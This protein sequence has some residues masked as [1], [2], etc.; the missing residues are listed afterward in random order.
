M[1]YMHDEILCMLIFP[2]FYFSLYLCFNAV[3][4]LTAAINICMH[5]YQA[6]VKTIVLATSN[7]C[8]IDC[9]ECKQRT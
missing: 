1:H 8:V 6:A 9:N 4:G 5:V 7:R 2:I 3:Y